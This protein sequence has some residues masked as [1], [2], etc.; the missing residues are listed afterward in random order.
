MQPSKLVA[1]DYD[2]PWKEALD[3]Y[4]EECLAL[5]FPAIH[6]LIDWTR[7]FEF[8][9]KELQQ[10]VRDAESGRR[11]VDK[12]V[13]VWLRDGSERWILIHIEVQGDEEPHFECRMYVYNFRLFDRYER[14]VISLAVL[15]DDNP[16]WRPGRYYSE[17]G[18]CSV[19]FRFPIAKLSDL[20]LRWSELE[21][22]GNRMAVVVMASLKAK[23]TTRDS[24]SRYQ[25]K[26]AIV[27]GLY[28]RGWSR[29][30]VLELF[31]LIDWMM[32]LPEDLAR[33]FEMDLAEIEEE[34]H[35]PY[36]TSIERLGMQ[37]GLE[38]GLG[39]GLAQGMRDTI[40][41]VIEVRFG[42][43]SEAVAAEVAAISNPSVLRN[44][45]AA[46]MTAAS[47]EDL[48]AIWRDEEAVP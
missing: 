13:R 33:A 3:F 43:I 38:Q 28:E 47:V 26:R 12:L 19:D 34:T 4:F 40:K 8:L 1:P 22:S 25:W 27:R 20:A 41:A 48:R 7:G 44:A 42:H 21:Q 16:Q 6:G 32:S 9:D 2:S 46:V 45:R 5:L 35:M 14:P 18:G 39:Q 24:Q 36:V 10:V 23:E 15:T 29:E 30:D 11:Y 17:L 37:R 31:R